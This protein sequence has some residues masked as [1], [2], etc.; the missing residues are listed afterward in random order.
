VLKSGVWY[1]VASDRS[2]IRG[3]R[4][5]RFTSVSVRSDVAMHPDGFNLAAFWSQW[6]DDFEASRPHTDV[7]I[8]IQPSAIP[9]LQTALGTQARAAVAD[10]ARAARRTNGVLLITVPFERLVDAHRALLGLGDHVE[11]VEP[12]ELRRR[13]AST[14]RA[15]ANLY[16]GRRAA[17]AAPPA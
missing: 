6:L 9:H 8:R 2:D 11:V 3:Y 7:L 12:A 17:V 14:A 13:I 15:V 16:A 4:V 5:A 1:L 10:R